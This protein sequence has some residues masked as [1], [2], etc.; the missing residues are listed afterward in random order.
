MYVLF[1]SSGS[2]WLFDEGEMETM[3]GEPNCVHAEGDDITTVT[4]V[5]LTRCEICTRYHHHDDACHMNK[6]FGM[7]RSLSL[8]LVAHLI[9]RTIYSMQCHGALFYRFGQRPF[10]HFC[11]QPFA[12][13]QL[14]LHVLVCNRKLFAGFWSSQK[15][16]SAFNL[17]TRCVCFCTCV[18]VCVRA[19]C[20]KL[21]FMLV[22]YTS[23]FQRATFV[24]RV[25]VWWRD[26]VYEH[27]YSITLQRLQNKFTFLYLFTMF[28]YFTIFTLALNVCELAGKMSI[29]CDDNDTHTH[30]HICARNGTHV[31]VCLVS[32]R[33]MCEPWNERDFFSV[34]LADW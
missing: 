32:M 34:C 33:A 14:W 10:A 8:S 13:S 17:L 1:S 20:V 24:I 6:V 23:F 11:F 9:I 16:L 4:G 27:F 22:L 12:H 25:W 28:C 7:A 2:T 31:W 5:F 30:S 18:W 19:R 3:Y 29:C 26:C 15:V 21:S